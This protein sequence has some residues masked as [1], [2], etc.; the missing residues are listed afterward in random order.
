MITIDPISISV[1][2]LIAYQLH[3]LDRKI[4]DT[5]KRVDRI[6]QKVKE[7]EVVER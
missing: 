6:H 1:L 2:G 5:N 4:K 7:I 3:A